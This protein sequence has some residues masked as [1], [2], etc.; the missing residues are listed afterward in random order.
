MFDTDGRGNID[1][2]LGAAVLEQ[3]KVVGDF[4]RDGEWHEFDIALSQFDW[5]KVSIT[6]KDNIFAFL[7]TPTEGTIICVDAVYIYE[8]E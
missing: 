2:N 3:G 1:W 7:S 8:K 6:K 4:D 5:S